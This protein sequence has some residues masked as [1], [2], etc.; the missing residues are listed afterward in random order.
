[1]LTDEMQQRPEMAEV[2][3]TLIRVRL[4]NGI[5]V[6][7]SQTMQL[8]RFQSMFREATECMF[9]TRIELSITS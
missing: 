2:D 3:R 1:M 9:C 7:P 4:S 5:K 8:M 6:L